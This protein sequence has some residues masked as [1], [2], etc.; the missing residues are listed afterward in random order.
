[1]LWKK[2]GFNIYKRS[3]RRDGNIYKKLIF[4]SQKKQLDKLPPEIFK[5]IVFVNN[6]EINKYERKI[7]SLDSKILEVIIPENEYYP[8]TDALN[9]NGNQQFADNIYKYLTNGLEINCLK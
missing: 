3:K 6:G 1:M 8:N 5:K 9:N 7:L 4:Y 2:E